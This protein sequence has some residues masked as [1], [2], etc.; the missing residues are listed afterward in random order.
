MKIYTKEP[1]KKPRMDR[2]LCVKKGSTIRDMAAQIHK[3][4]IR[5]F[6]FARV[7]GKS[8]RFAGQ[9]VGLD[10][11]LEDEDIVEIHLR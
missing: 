6:R 2:P 5:K 8:A 10:H 4:F 1:G 7:W 3:D 11:P 9:Q